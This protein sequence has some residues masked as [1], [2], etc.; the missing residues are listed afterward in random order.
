MIQFPSV[1]IQRA[2][3]L[4]LGILFLL[5]CGVKEDF[6]VIDYPRDP[7]RPVVIKRAEEIIELEA[8]SI[9]EHITAEMIDKAYKVREASSRASSGTWYTGR[10]AKLYRDLL[11]H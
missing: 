3:S 10:D 6:T 7:D 8:P 5:G 9:R 1:A 2:I 11:A 4:H